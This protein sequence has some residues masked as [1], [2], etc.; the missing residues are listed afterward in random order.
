MDAKCR[1]LIIITALWIIPLWVVAFFGLGAI[2][3]APFAIVGFPGAIGGLGGGA[4]VV[5]RR[6]R[7]SR[8]SH[9]PD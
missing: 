7:E 1:R 2:V 9:P 3:D 6:C 5:W 8:S 4:L